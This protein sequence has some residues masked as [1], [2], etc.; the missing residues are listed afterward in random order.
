[1]VQ[2]RGSGAVEGHVTPRMPKEILHEEPKFVKSYLKFYGT[3]NN[4]Q[5]G[6]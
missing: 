5:L 1:M 2:V 6:Y 4:L 3:S